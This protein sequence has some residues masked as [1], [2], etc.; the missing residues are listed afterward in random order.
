MNPGQT[1]LN[2]ETRYIKVLAL[3]I[4]FLCGYFAF[5][6]MQSREPTSVDFFS[7]PLPLCGA[8]PNCVCSLQNPA[9]ARYIEAIDPGSPGLADVIDAI[10]SIDG[11][12]GAS[13]GT[14][15]HATFT[16]CI[17]GYVD[18]LVIQFNNGKLDVRSSSRVGHSDFGVNR[19]RVDRLRKVLSGSAAS[20]N[21]GE[22]GL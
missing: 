4:V 21:T 5:K 11:K 13:N 9:D 22:S 1:H 15:I 20:L 14:T 17:F 6:G 8:K 16:S 10:G 19:K 18:D 3:L 2:P 12:I 7:G